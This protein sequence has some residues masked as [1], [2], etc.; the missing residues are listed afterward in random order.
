VLPSCIQ[1]AA[2]IVESAE[3]VVANNARCTDLAEH[4]AMIRRQLDQLQV[5]MARYIPRAVC[6]IKRKLVQ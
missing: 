1:L 3:H 6:L 5:A 2:N 4:V